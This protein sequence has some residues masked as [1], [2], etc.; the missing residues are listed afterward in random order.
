MARRNASLALLIVAAVV[1]A[2]DTAPETAA[3]SNEINAAVLAPEQASNPNVVAQRVGSFGGMFI[4]D[5]GRP[6]VYLT[7]MADAATA[8]RALSEFAAQNGS[9]ADRDPVPASLV[10]ICSAR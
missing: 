3:P 9:S 2:C 7:N 8:R 4:D 1:A 5:A 6:T 10:S